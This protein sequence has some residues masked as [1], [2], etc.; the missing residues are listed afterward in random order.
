[1][2]RIR[3]DKTKLHYFSK[4]YSKVLKTVYGK[5]FSDI[6]N[7][8]K[9]CAPLL[10]WN[11]QQYVALLVVLSQS[12]M[13][14]KWR[15]H[16]SREILVTIAIDKRY[17]MQWVATHIRNSVHW[18]CAPRQILFFRGNSLALSRGT[19]FVLGIC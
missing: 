7:D 3:Y 8:P 13:F 18:N 1:M 14:T 12:V 2:P 5:R 6:C 15:W 10:S 9:Q 16:I 4:K 11:C 19:L 17:A